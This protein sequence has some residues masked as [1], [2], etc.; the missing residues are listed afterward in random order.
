MQPV[1]EPA[2]DLVAAPTDRHQRAELL[3]ER[4]RLNFRQLVAGIVEE[5]V[6]EAAAH[7]LFHA[8]R[9]GVLGHDRGRALRGEEGLA[10]AP[11]G[12]VGFAK[13]LER[14]HLDLAAS[15]D[16]RQRLEL[17]ARILRRHLA[18][19]EAGTGLAEACFRLDAPVA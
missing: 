13:P 16:R 1:G 2:G 9:R 8:P 12:G 3:V 19:G 18:V 17:R 11:L 6:L 10:P 14:F 5:Q 15:P 4:Q 7:R